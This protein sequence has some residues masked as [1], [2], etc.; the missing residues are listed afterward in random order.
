M[1]RISPASGSGVLNTASGR[2]ALPPAYCVIRPPG[3]AVRPDLAAIAI[4]LF[5]ALPAS[6]QVVIRD[7]VGSDSSTT[8][9]QT[10]TDLHQSIWVCRAGG[11]LLPRRARIV[12]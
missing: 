3:A 4:A 6:A 10:G 5:L 9:G 2:S 8:D 12:P 11:P 7:S 1:R